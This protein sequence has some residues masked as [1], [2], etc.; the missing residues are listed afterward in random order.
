M[1]SRRTAAAVLAGSL[2]LGLACL[3]LVSRSRAASDQSQNG[4]QPEVAGPAAK[5]VGTV[6]ALSGN[7][8]TLTTDSGST[9]DILVQESTRLVRIAPGQKDL[10]DAAPV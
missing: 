10:K 7:V 3:V 8:I 4:Q 2:M 9:V 6:K 1:I 5:P